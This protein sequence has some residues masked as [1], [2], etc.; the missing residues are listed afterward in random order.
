[1]SQYYESASRYATNAFIRS[2][3]GDG[4]VKKEVPPQIYEHK[5]EAEQALSD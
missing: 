3:L 2:Q 4:L 5:E 1:V